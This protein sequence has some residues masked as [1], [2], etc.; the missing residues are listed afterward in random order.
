MVK[1]YSKSFIFQY[2]YIFITKIVRI[3][4][5]HQP[6]WKNPSHAKFLFPTQPWRNNSLANLYNIAHDEVFKPTNASDRTQGKVN[7]PLIDHKSF[8]ISFLTRK[9]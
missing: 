3:I 6:G 2:T 5:K 7:F 9:S 4:F 8:S 1:K